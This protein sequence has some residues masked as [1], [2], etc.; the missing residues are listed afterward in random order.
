MDGPT[1]RIRSRVGAHESLTAV[2][3]SIRVLFPD[4]NPD[5]ENNETGFPRK[6]TWIEIHGEG[7]SLNRFLQALRDQRILDTGMDAMTMDSTGESTLFRLSRQAAIV[8]KV[9]FILEGETSFGGHFEVLLESKGLLHW[10]EKA[11][12]HEGRN[13]V[14]RSVGD[15]YGMEMDGT[16]REWNDE[17]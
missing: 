5:N 14:P 1:V 13:H 2:I 16:S 17:D 4:F 8:G 3:E 11:T 7:G 10:I 15:G 6:N 12:F 9:G